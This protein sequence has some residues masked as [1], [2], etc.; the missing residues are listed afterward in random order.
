MP[1][2]GYP[3][4]FLQGLS[5]FW[6]R[7]FADSAQLSSLY[8]GSAILIGQAYLD[9]MSSVL[10]VS[11]RDALALDREAYKLIVMRE[12]ELRF[13]EGD[14]VDANRWAFDLP[15][16]VVQFS[17]LDNRVF[18]PTASLET[19]RDFEIEDGVLL[20]KVDPTDP[21]GTGVPLD[22]FARRA[23]DVDVGGKF[24]DATVASWLSA[25]IKKGDTLRILDVG[26]D[27]AQR[28]R[29]DHEITL[30]RAAAV[31][32]SADDDL[33][34]PTTGVKYAVLRVPSENAI[35]ESVTLVGVVGTLLHSRVDQGSLRVYARNDAGADVV[36]GVD[37]LVNYEAGTFTRISVLPWQSEPGPY[38]VTY[39]WRTELRFAQ[40]GVIAASTSTAR[41]VQI[42]TW[43]PDTLI[44]RR[45]LANNFGAL[46]GREQPSSEAYRAFLQGIFQLYLLGPVLERVESAL[47][48][49]LG[50][51]VV[52]EDDEIVQSVDTSDLLVNRVLTTRPSTGQT[53]TY[54]FPKG[55]PLRED[56]VAGLSL[57]SFEPLSEAITVT[58]YVESP[59]W[60]H[61]AVIPSELFNEVNGAVP[62]VARRTASPS[63]V[64]HV[65]GAADLAECGDPGLYVGGDETGF[66]IPL[67]P[68]LADIGASSLIQTSPVNGGAPTGEWG[69]VL[70]T[71]TGWSNGYEFRFSIL[72]TLPSGFV[73]LRDGAWFDVVS[74]AWIDDDNVTGIL[75]ASL[76]VTVAA[77]EAAV[78]ASTR[79]WVEDPDVLLPT[80][81]IVLVGPPSMT[82]F[83]FA[84]GEDRTL[85]RRRMAF[86]LMDRYLKH[87]TFTVSFDTSVVSLAAGA[88]F[89]QGL[90]DLNELVVGS[91]PSHTYAFTSPD[92]FFRDEIA[93]TDALSFDRQV[94]SRVFGP[95]QV[96]F[97]DDAPIVGGGV[98]TVGDYARYESASPS[99]AFASIG[100]PVTLTG[101]PTAPRHGR[102]V[103]IYVNGTIGG[104]RLIENVDYSVD[105]AL[106]TVTRLTAWDSNT[107]P[108]YYLQ[109]N[110]G[111]IVDAPAGTSDMPLTVSCVDPAIITATFD[112]AAAQWDG[113]AT[114]ATAPRD[115]GMVERAIMV[116]AHP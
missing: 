63:Y 113:T 59:A 62:N 66:V 85:F 52:G 24:T 104:K 71:L 83:T 31:Y 58:D 54:T 81:F 37:Y 97:A 87:H 106:R 91:K 74:N 93:V 111:N 69:A 103:R 53:A 89:E 1:A 43:A 32:V 34:A 65:V 90:R 56:L 35:E 64:A 45:T 116:N 29:S 80:D 9:L 11:L 22:G 68:A 7:F 16:P 8:K 41:V 30:V 60:W 12:D 2:I 57:L 6:Q 100:V 79:I 18:E 36:E 72:S 55:V 15:E 40:V 47:N 20:F 49:V 73:E 105:Y 107:V 78:G 38:V 101:A 109:L 115:I 108:V 114:P 3:Y 17:M 14:S 23:L 75:V 13:V 33:P 102:F 51:P 10:S 112:P 98:W 95:D 44:D 27:G 50:L 19:Q 28:K 67:T 48:V 110:I 5:D 25:G 84:E 21:A 26:T 86:V 99:T 82:V 46:I 94:G 61:S 96:V 42:A 39:A 88:A 77:V 92:T 76:G 70:E 4:S